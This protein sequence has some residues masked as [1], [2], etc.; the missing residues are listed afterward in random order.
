[1]KR[2][3]CF[4]LVLISLSGIYA[5]TERRV[6]NAKQLVAAIRSNTT[7]ILKPGVYDLSE[8]YGTQGKE[9]RWDE[10]YDGSEL[11]LS[12]ISNLTLQGEEGVEIVS[13]AL[14]AFILTLEDCENV[15]LTDLVL[16]HEPQGEC[17][18]GV[19]RVNGGTGIEINGCELYGCG[20]IGLECRN[21]YS[22]NVDNSVIR[23]CSYG[24]VDVSDT[25]YLYFLSTT[26]S[27]NGSYPLI[28]ARQTEELGINSCTISGN[29]GDTL[30]SVEG[31]GSFVYAEFS[32]I[33][34]NA[35]NY[36]M[37]DES[38]LY[39]SVTECFFDGNTFEE[40][41][42]MEDDYSYDEVPVNDFYFDYD[43]GLSFMYPLGWSLSEG[44]NGCVFSLT[45]PD[46]A[47]DVVFMK[48]LETQGNLNIERSGERLFNSA[49]ENL[50]KQL[51][52]G[53]AVSIRFSADTAVTEGPEFYYKD[54]SGT[55]RSLGGE[56]VNLRFRLIAVNDAIYGF[57]GIADPDSLEENSWTIDTLMYS[58]TLMPQG[59]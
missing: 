56:S 23:N 54:F 36:F 18:G 35:V 13:P 55:G 6:E 38:S 11:V 50:G 26:F 34:N 14:Y 58:I 39:L 17:S 53:Y 33:E 27:D 12:G 8:A 32:T 49:I 3:M 31:E 42:F 22:V 21:A 19:I 28:N 9:T 37:N 41:S 46:E 43:S 10:V 44:E 15:V 51:G 29:E 45:D 24:A 59:E 7:V 20:T 5:Q 16:G 40:P 25:S 52:E 1:M 30:F 48:L 47:I 57:G 4:L 2:I